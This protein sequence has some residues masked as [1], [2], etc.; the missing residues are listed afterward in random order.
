MAQITVVYKSPDL[1]RSVAATEEQF[2]ASTVRE[3][4]KQIRERHGKDA[5]KLAK[6]K[7][8]TINGLSIQTKHYYATH[9]AEGDLLGFFSLAAGG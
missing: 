7:L 4:L 8:I 5:Y 9:L 2:D 6:S 3:V 1:A